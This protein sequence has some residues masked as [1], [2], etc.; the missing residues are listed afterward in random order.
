VKI[1]VFGAGMQGTLLALRLAQAGH[2]V[3]VVARGRR[4]AELRDR[5]AIIEHA[6]SGLRETER[7]PVLDELKRDF[8]ADC[9]LV[10]VRRDQLDQALPA[11][12]GARNIGRFVL[13]VNHGNGLKS[14]FDAIGRTRVVIGFP[15][16]AGS[17]EDGIDWYVEVAEQ[18]FVIESVAPDIARILRGAH[19]KVQMVQ[20][21]DSW[22]RRH[23]IFVTAIGGALCETNGD[24]TR[25]S[26]DKIRV[27]ELISAVREGWA[28]LDRQKVAPAPLA[29]RAIFQWVPLP[30]AVLYWG[31]L[32]ASPRGENYFARHT[33]H[34]PQELSALAA[35]VRAFLPSDAIPKL[36]R[37]YA[38]IDRASARQSAAG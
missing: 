13:M 29:L 31:R 20:D 1:V 17:I 6:I 3:T 2:E 38:A 25:L 11:L 8:C 37:L 12:A 23:A 19:F 30:W 22:L 9:C 27:R 35:D 4:A 5:G 33:R 34:A 7:L 15:G 28:A 16:A 26:A 14:L 10:A 36:E 21:M 24:S 32:L 18:P